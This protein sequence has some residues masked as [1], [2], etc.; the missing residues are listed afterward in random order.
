MVDTT[1][2]AANSS[3]LACLNERTLIFFVGNVLSVP[4]LSLVGVWGVWGAVEVDRLPAGSSQSVVRDT[5]TNKLTR[6]ILLPNIYRYQSSFQARMRHC[7]QPFCLG[8]GIPSSTQTPWSV[9]HWWASFCRALHV[10]PCFSMS[11]WREMDFHA[12]LVVS[13]PQ[14]FIALESLCHG[15]F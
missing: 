14:G 12:P 2:V 8:H 11:C 6:G 3:S 7:C 15:K 4:A 1:F 9:F 10:Q 5:A 13:S